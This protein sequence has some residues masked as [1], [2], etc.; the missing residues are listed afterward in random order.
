MQKKMEG[1]LFKIS[2]VTE[3]YPSLATET[4]GLGS[5]LRVLGKSQE[6]LSVSVSSWSSLET[7]FFMSNWE[8][9]A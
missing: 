6:C 4:E 8:I 3:P 2:S 1:V 9:R 5:G 7:R